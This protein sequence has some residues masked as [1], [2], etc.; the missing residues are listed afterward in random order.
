MF[1]CKQHLTV[2]KYK[3]KWRNLYMS[4]TL[5]DCIESIWQILIACKTR[6]HIY[7]WTMKM[8]QMQLIQSMFRWFTQ[9]CRKLKCHKI[10]VYRYNIYLN[11]DLFVILSSLQVI[12]KH[13]I[14]FIIYYYVI[15]YVIWSGT[16]VDVFYV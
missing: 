8:E 2:D 7:V 3:E 13:F 16:D 12:W 1:Q 15:T 11:I 9:M 5:C 6:I 4:D 10:C 14:G